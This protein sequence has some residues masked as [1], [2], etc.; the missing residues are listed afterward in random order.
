M[1]T[2]DDAS[3]EQRAGELILYRGA[4]GGPA[5]DVRLDGDTVWLTQ[6]Q[7]V[8]LFDSSKANISEHI[9]SIY[10]EGELLREATVRD[11]RTVRAALPCS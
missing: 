8:S 4:D 11:F 10:A 7:L 6:A 5:I 2:T 9:A 1:A 3:H